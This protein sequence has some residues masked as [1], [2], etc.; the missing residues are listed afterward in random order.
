MLGKINVVNLPRAAPSRAAI[1]GTGKEWSPET[2][3]RNLLTKSPTS[4]VDI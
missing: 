1:T 3:A 4:E 2:I